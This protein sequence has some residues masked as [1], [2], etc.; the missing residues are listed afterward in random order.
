MFS[1]NA[2]MV[3]KA[4]LRLVS[5]A[6]TVVC[7]SSVH[8]PVGGGGSPR[9]S[10]PRSSRTQRRKPS[11]ASRCAPA[12]VAPSGFGSRCRDGGTGAGNRRGRRA[13]RPSRPAST[14]RAAR[15]LFSSVDGRRHDP[16]QGLQVLLRAS[17]DADDVAGAQSVPGPRELGRRRV[18][19]EIDD[20]QVRRPGRTLRAVRLLRSRGQCPRRARDQKQRQEVERT[21]SLAH[22]TGYDRLLSSMSPMSP[23]GIGEFALRNR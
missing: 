12:L 6:V 17:P 15:R 10:M 9:T 20:A 11:A 18:R 23:T 7:S 19:L 2:A 1:R 22:V 14:W 8:A 13:P 3:C 21:T 4:T 16:E 5:D